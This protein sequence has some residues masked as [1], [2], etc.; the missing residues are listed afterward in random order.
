MNCSERYYLVKYR[1]RK[2]VA[3]WKECRSCRKYKEF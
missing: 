1:I 3:E 2:Y